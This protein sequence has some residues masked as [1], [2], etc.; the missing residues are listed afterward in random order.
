[1][2]I[3]PP[4]H[5][6]LR[7]KALRGKG[8]QSEHRG[9][10]A[11]ARWRIWAGT[12]LLGGHQ[13]A[14][15]MVPVLIGVTIDTA[16][17]TGEWPALAWCI[18]GLVVLFSFLTL[19][20]RHGARFIENASMA[21]AHLLRGSMAVR[22]LDSRGVATDRASGELVAIASSDADAAATAVEARAG[23]IAAVV[24]LLA[25]VGVLVDINPWLALLVL[26]GA[27]L[28]LLVLAA[29][30]KPIAGRRGTAQES[31][32]QTSALATDLMRG[33]R[34]LRG[35]GAAAPASARYR[36]ASRKS[37]D[38]SLRAAR[39]E[40]FQTGTA[41]ALNG[42]FLAVVAVFAGLLT[43]DGSLSA[44]QLITVVGL[45]QFMAEPVGSIAFRLKSL[46]V[47]NASARRVEEVLNAPWLRPDSS[48]VET[49]AM[50]IAQVNRMEMPEDAA[51]PESTPAPR[52]VLHR[53][54]AGSLRDVSVDLAPGTL[55]AIAGN[56]PRDAISIFDLLSGRMA[57]DSMQGSVLVG[58]L[59]LFDLSTD[60]LRE[61]VLAEPYQPDFFEGT[62]E[63][64]L[65]GLATVAELAL[66]PALSMTH[67]A[68]SASA[69][70]EMI[71]SRTRGLAEV[72]VDRGASMSG[73]QRQRLGLARALLGDPPLLILNEPT[74]AV[75]AMTEKVIADGVRAL[76]HGRSGN[77]GGKV[78][79]STLIITNSPVLLDA[80]DR[81]LM[82]DHGAV[83]LDGNHADLLDSSAAYRALVL[84]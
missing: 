11:A 25:A 24:G 49:E 6:K 16:V 30:T 63:Q 54:S 31:A 67:P 23:I 84:R 9:L 12:I 29:F 8:G 73:G 34:A 58:E 76:R 13:L 61:L 81:V 4:D 28:I 42:I 1:M 52:L 39:V 51:S 71:G 82:L 55:L 60:R 40:A 27:P 83:V 7:T 14:E 53:V 21:R 56:D 41:A 47:A 66:L 2:P 17:D 22:L 69:A 37:L 74:T 46:A 38:A 18:A 57:A 75:D 45:A 65:R 33:L 43:L 20:W 35:I 72:V 10:G 32:G 80:A 64:N 59:G 79:R 26:A 36:Q 5:G 62:L 70:D 19:C 3:S 15:A 78:L 77:Q 48:R 44:G 68:L 50:A